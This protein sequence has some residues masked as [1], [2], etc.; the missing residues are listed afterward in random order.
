[1]IAILLLA[2]AARD[3]VAD[4]IVKLR[5]ATDVNQRYQISNQLYTL[6][7]PSHVPLLAKEADAGPAPVRVILIHELARLQTKDAV[8]VLRTLS[9]KYDLVSRAEAAAQLRWLDDETGLPILLALLPKAQS[10]EEKRA[11]LSG[12]FGGFGTEGGADIVR[13]VTKFLGEEKSEDLRR[14]ALQILGYQKDASS[15]P[16]LKKISTDPAD[17]LR[18][19]ALSQLIRRGE[20]DALEQGLK[21]LEEEKVAG[22]SIHHLL[23][24]IE[25][26]GKRTAL[27][28]LREMLEKAADR[29][30]RTALISTLA[31]MK[32][33]KSIPLLSKLSEDADASISRAAL[34]GIIKL[35]GKGQLELL[36]KVA[37]EGD[38]S[39]RLEAAA[40]LLQLDLREGFD[41]VKAELAGDKSYY[42]MS[43]VS[44]L[45]KVRRKESVD[46]LLPL[47]D[48]SD[49]N[50]RRQARSA[51]HSALASL[52]PYLKFEPNAAPDKIRAWWEKNRPK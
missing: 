47:L 16:V 13:A 12:L 21:A 40:A 46:L 38:S 49:E 45:G 19:E 42:R 18:Y 51:V 11:V 10:P 2:L 4:L 35:A 14:E 43:A 5:A 32:D 6:V 23:N 34:D 37:T 33:D 9:Q 26:S 31:S 28:R 3:E 39:K 48:D 15:L 17:S 25:N 52:F 50:V 30:L 36:R 20:D 29:S 44:V 7:K 22:L 27:P 1:M 41:G 8:A 24:A